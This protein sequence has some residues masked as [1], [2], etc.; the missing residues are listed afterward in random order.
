[1]FCYCYCRYFSGNTVVARAIKN[2]DK[3]DIIAGELRSDFHPETA[4]S[5]AAGTITDKGPMAQLPELNTGPY[6]W[7]TSAYITSATGPEDG[8][9]AV[10][11]AWIT[12]TYVFC[13][14]SR[15]CLL[16]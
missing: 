1:M 9:P 4:Q 10:P 3:D 8:L 14:L 5:E 16:C 7:G 6:R 12:T 11:Q 15:H 13:L 2:I